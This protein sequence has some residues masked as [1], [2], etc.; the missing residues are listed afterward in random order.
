MLDVNEPANRQLQLELEKQVGV[1]VDRRGRVPAIIVAPS[2][3]GSQPGAMLVGTIDIARE[4]PPLI[5]RGLEVGGAFLPFSLDTTLQKLRQ[6]L[7]ATHQASGAKPQPTAST[8]QGEVLATPTPTGQ[9]RAIHIAYFA[10]PGCPECTRAQYDFNLLVHRYPQVK[11]AHFQTDEDAELQRWLKEQADVPQDRRGTTPATFIGYSFLLGG[12]INYTNLRVLVGCYLHTGAPPLW[13]IWS[14][15]RTRAQKQMLRLFQSLIP[16]TAVAARLR[17]G[18]SPYAP[19]LVMLLFTCLSLDDRKRGDTFLRWRAFTPGAYLGLLA[20]GLGLLKT[21][22]ASAALNLAGCGVYGL[23]ALL[24]LGLAILALYDGILA[25][26]GQPLNMW[27]CP[28]WFVY[29]FLRNRAPSPIP[30]LVALALGFGASLPGALYQNR[31][32]YPDTFTFTTSLAPLRSRAVV[33]LSLHNLGFTL[34]LIIAG[35]SISTAITSQRLNSF[36][37]CQRTLTDLPT[38]GLCLLLGIWLVITM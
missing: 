33:Y 22:E 19:A 4:L 9:P 14:T 16:A 15:K 27:L 32:T 2:H 35:Y 25:Y 11:V 1:P 18:L 8:P 10:T 26:R 23:A 13:E 29:T 6:S 21:P 37:S 17:N 20:A 28:P 38:A 7:T 24:C 36:T 30:A 31:Q 34:P 12:K 5:Q 3:D